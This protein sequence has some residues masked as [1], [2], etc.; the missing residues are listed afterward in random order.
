MAQALTVLTAPIF[1][2]ILPPESFGTAA[3]F[4]SITTILSVVA[5]LR[6]EFAILLP[7]TE[8]EAANVFA[9]SIGAVFLVTVLTLSAIV[10]FGDEILNWIKAPQLS[11]YLWLIPLTVLFNGITNGLNYWISRT[12]QFGK[13]SFA[14]VLGAITIILFQSLMVIHGERHA[15]V[16]ILSTVAG[17]LLMVAF[18]MINVWS[19][20]RKLLISSIRLRKM[21]ESLY[22][23]RKFPLI[24]SLGGFANNISWQLPPLLLSR[25]FNPA[26]VGQYSLAYRLIHLPM[27]LI[28]SSIAQVFS[29]KIS[30]VRTDPE[31]V[32]RIVKTAFEKLVMIG[33]L[34]AILLSLVGEELF[35]L[36]FG[37]NWTLA[38]Q[39]VQILGLWL[40][41][42]FISSPLS[43]IFVIYEKQERIL[44]IHLAILATR[45]VSLVVGGLIGDALLAIGLFSISGVLVY[46][47]LSI[48]NMLI[49][50]VSLRESLTVILRFTLKSIPGALLLFLLSNVFHLNAYVLVAIAGIILIFYYSLYIIGDHDLQVYRISVL[51]F[52]ESSSKDKR[53][54]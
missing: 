12:K 2:R 46:G 28:G 18:L 33:L 14:R 36:I 32:R 47:S 7:S 16:I 45:V 21:R 24:D 31:Q 8:D 37:E 23:Y 17:S 26:I 22:R 30:S 10:L 20:N 5:C 51:T 49:A 54:Q 43:T 3:I 41:F 4:V 15:G 19:V 13:L 52:R 1:Y 35:V 27:S 48:W 25:Y 9:V 50:G 44:L 11:P 39:F 34:P 40:F 29:Q 6:Y 38:G 42:W 53:G